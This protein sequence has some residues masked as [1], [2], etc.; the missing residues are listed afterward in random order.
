MSMD[1]FVAEKENKEIQEEQELIAEKMRL[2]KKNE[3]VGVYFNKYNT[4]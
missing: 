4:V 3:T 1:S 2:F